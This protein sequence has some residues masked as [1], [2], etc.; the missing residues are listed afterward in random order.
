MQSSDLET[1][2][3]SPMTTQKREGPLGDAIPS[4]NAP[5]DQTDGGQKPEKVE[6]RPDVGTVKPED[7]P[8][9]DRARGAP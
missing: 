7:Y 2:R 5:D 8:A 4:K 3:T 6:D 9:E 1:G